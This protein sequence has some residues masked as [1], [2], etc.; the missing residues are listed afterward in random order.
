[1][2]EN[3]KIKKHIIN[4]YTVGAALVV[5]AIIGVSSAFLLKDSADAAASNKKQI[6]AKAT[7]SQFSFA[8]TANWHK[9]P[10][11]QT[12]MALFSDNGECF[13]SIEHKSGTIDVTSAIKKQETGLQSSGGSM[14][15]TADV[16]ATIKVNN[17][18]QQY[19]LHQFS[20]SSSA[21]SQKLMGGLGLGFIQL[22]DGYLEVQEHCNTAD[23]LSTV[24]PAVQAYE[25]DSA[26]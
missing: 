12:S 24:L 9:G 26:K 16:T 8:G 15:A 3:Q 13:A 2:K 18:S 20:L 19:E 17:T 1:M 6:V 10:T 23:E 7:P 4:R 22:S 25:F 14:T 5:V 11:N 21:S